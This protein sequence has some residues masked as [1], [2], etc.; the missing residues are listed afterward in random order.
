[1]LELKKQ[2][3]AYILEIRKWKAAE[4]KVINPR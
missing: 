4:D 1:M 3:N 2:S